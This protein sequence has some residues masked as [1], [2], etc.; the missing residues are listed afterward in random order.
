MANRPDSDLTELLAETIRFLTLEPAPGGWIGQPPEWPGEYLFGG[1]VVAQ[2]LM[3]ASRDVQ[4]LVN[5][6]GRGLLRGVM[7]N[8]DGHI[9]ASV[10]QEMLLAVI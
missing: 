9:V 10:A 3:A 2:A 7:R 5:A 1:F 8:P 4:S 6:G